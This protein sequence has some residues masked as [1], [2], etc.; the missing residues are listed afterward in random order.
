MRPTFWVVR[1]KVMPQSEPPEVLYHYTSAEGLSGILKDKLVRATVATYLNDSREYVHGV[2]IAKDLIKSRLAGQYDDL[3]RD[4]NSYVEYRLDHANDGNDGRQICVFSLSKN[5]DLLSQWRGYCPMSGGYS[6]GFDTKALLPHLER[7]KF[8]LAQ[9]EYERKKQ[10]K[11]VEPVLDE[12]VKD[13]RDLPTTESL[14][15]RLNKVIEGVFIKKFSR[16]APLLKDDAFSQEEEWRAVS[17]LISH[18]G[19]K[20]RIKSSL[21]IPYY[22]LNVCEPDG[23]WPLKEII[24]GPM[25]N[26]PLAEDGVKVMLHDH[27]IVGDLPRVAR[28]KIPYRPV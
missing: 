26:Q 14:Q 22:P 18:R 6:L 23:F 17:E 20:Y 1:M 21:A 5:G 25:A 16:I 9:C 2:D 19:L 7:Q 8:R 15:V 27:G 3:S 11:L 13:F 4:F 12:A 28:S 10:K 24:V